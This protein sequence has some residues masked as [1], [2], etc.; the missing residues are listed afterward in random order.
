MKHKEKG[1]YTAETCG[2]KI[3]MKSFVMIAMAIFLIGASA[4]YAASANSF[5]EQ[6]SKLIAAAKK[7]GTLGIA[8]GGAPSRQYRP[9]LAEFQKKF[10]IRPEV[11]TGGAR[12]TINRVL[13]ERKAGRFSFDVALISV[14]INNQ[15]LVPAG[16]LVPFAPLLIHPEVVDTSK[17]YGD[18]HWYGDKDLKYT[19][20]Y[21]AASED[22]YEMWY[23]TD[24]ISSEEIKTIKSQQD[25]FD[26]RWKGK[27]QGNGMGDPSGIRQMIDSWFDPDRGPKWVKTYLTEA[28]VTFSDDRRILETWLVGGRF[29]LRAVSTAEEELRTLAK[30]GL[31]IKANFLPKRQGI[32]RA[33][34]S[35]CC[36]SVFDNA[37]HPNAAKLFANWFLTK[38]A[39]TLTH[40]L[41]PN[42]DRSS[43]RTDVPWGQVVED[44]R[45]DNSKKY[46]FPD[47]EPESGAK[48]EEAQKEILKIWEARQK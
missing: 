39:Q 48:H 29:P 43:L 44:Q 45:R 8:A 19:F 31:P 36:I 26:P 6:W 17:W 13:A 40:T 7:E 1:C 46:S 23:N 4:A 38:E 14:R 12:D 34:G 3:P 16:S 25:F 15:R 28:G 47:A 5:D 9:V 41:I 37:P 21:H 33:A 35:G 27:I 10:G 30:K 24:K 20:I 42:I 32:L 18:K 2:R 22:E 11:S